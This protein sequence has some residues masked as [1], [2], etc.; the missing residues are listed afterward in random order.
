MDHVQGKIVAVKCC[1]Q[2]VTFWGVDAAD[3]YRLAK[4]AAV[5]AF[6]EAFKKVKK[7]KFLSKKIKSAQSQVFGNC[8]EN[9]YLVFQD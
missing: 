5:R 6:M 4:W 1:G 8:W 7:Q 2:K 3:S 9:C